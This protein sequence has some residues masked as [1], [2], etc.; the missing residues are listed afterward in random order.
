M[1]QNIWPHTSMRLPSGLSLASKA[2]TRHAFPARRSIP[3]FRTYCLR[4]E[5]F[6]LGPTLTTLYLDFEK[7]A[8]A[9]LALPP[10]GY[11][12]RLPPTRDPLAEVGTV[13]PRAL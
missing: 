7:A 1:R 3:P 2:V 13:R 9:A 10:G 8:G 5:R 11:S 12:N 6:G 4:R